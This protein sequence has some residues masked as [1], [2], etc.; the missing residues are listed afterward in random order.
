[1]SDGGMIIIIFMYCLSF[2]F[3]I[4]QYTI[5]DPY[6][7][8]LKDINGNPITTTGITS[9]IE[10]TRLDQI[11][12]S[13]ANTDTSLFGIEP[14]LA[15]GT[16]II[17]VFSLLTGTAVFQLLGYFGL[18]PIFINAIYTTICILYD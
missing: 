6:Y 9:L 17:Q 7:I 5:L 10:L 13:V 18:P 3:L 14:I 8:T 12:E 1:M 2:G 16:I 15:A 4:A 11:E